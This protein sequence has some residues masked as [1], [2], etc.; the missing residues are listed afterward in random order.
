MKTFPK[1]VVQLE[2]IVGGGQALGTLADGRKVFVWG[3]LPGEKVEV[4][5]TKSKS[6]MAE[7]VVTE[8]IE[9]SDERVEPKDPESYLSTSP[10]QIMSADAEARHKTTLINDAF[11]LHH[12]SLPSETTI[13]SDD[14][15]YGYRNKVEFSFYGS[16]KFRAG[17]RQPTESD[18]NTTSA[19]YLQ[20]EFVEAPGP[21]PEPGVKP[22]SGSRYEGSGRNGKG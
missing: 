20:P 5:L 8:V 7:A 16:T 18:P 14:K 2:K 10:W 9:P 19:I 13:Y 1:E 12:I 15:L 4:Q 6:K 21:S 3:G 11:E 17:N 22:W